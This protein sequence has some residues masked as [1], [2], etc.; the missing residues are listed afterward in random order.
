MN[1]IRVGLLL[2]TAVCLAGC[3]SKATTT[4][5]PPLLVRAQPAHFEAYATTISLTGAIQARTLADL[6]F[7]VSGRVVEWDADVGQR[8]EAGAVLAKIDPT[9][10]QA[11]LDAANAAVDFAEAVLR[12]ASTNFDRQK[13]LIDSGFTTRSTYD[14]A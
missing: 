2:A 10:Q 1:W 11:D 14:S 12:Q 7:R 5:R 6:S 4:T 8:V 13:S 3:G 9:E